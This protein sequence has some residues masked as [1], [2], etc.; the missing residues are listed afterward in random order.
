MFVD[1]PISSLSIFI[2][3]GIHGGVH[4]LFIVLYSTGKNQVYAPHTHTHTHTHTQT[5]YK[6]TQKLQ[7]HRD[8]EASKSDASMLSDEEVKKLTGKHMYIT[9]NPCSS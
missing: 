4:M 5:R 7:K 2:V 6:E 8:N 1:T 9:T 3:A